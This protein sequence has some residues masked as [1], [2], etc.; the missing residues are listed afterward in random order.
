MVEALLDT[1]VLVDLLRNYLPAVSW[2]KTQNQLMGVTSVTWMEVMFGAKNKT[3]QAMAIKMLKQFE[4][5]YLTQ[6]DQVWAMQQLQKYRLSH[7]LDLGDCL[8]AA[9][10]HRLQLPLY[11]HNLK[12]FTPLLGG[13]AQ[14]PYLKEST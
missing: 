11:T 3:K 10:S 5:V 6:E 13:L 1:V 2:I 4:M 9:P 7:N 14:A 12:H 8:I